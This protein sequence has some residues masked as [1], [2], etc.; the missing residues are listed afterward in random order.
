[1]GS[2]GV[3]GEEGRAGEVGGEEGMGQRGVGQ[4][5]LWQRG[6]AERGAVG[7]WEDRSWWSGC[8]HQLALHLKAKN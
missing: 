6:E 3:V 8:I 4:R 2:M 5:G 7:M 1:M